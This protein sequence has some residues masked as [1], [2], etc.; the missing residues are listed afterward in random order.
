MGNIERRDKIHF[1]KSTILLALSI[2]T[3]IILFFFIICLYLLVD[4]DIIAIE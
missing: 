4:Y 1:A 3:S 2:K